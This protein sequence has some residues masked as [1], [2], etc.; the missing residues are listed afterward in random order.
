MN[1]Q[2]TDYQDLHPIA[3]FVIFIF[4]IL[5]GFV[6]IICGILIFLKKILPPYK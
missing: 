1:T 3:G 5:C 4:V 2:T 6:T